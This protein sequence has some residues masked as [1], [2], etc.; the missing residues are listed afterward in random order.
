MIVNIT[1]TEHSQLLREVWISLKIQTLLMSI[2]RSDWVTPNPDGSVSLTST[3]HYE[4][5]ADEG[6]IQMNTE[7]I[8][9]GFDHYI[10]EGIEFNPD[11]TMD[12]IP[13]G[14][15]FDS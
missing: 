2:Q 13:E 6:N 10:P 15:S 7:Y 11:G 5:N 12:V 14:T 4:A 3:E 9:E 1:M 8:N